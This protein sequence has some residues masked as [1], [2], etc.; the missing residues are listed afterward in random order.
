MSTTVS[1]EFIDNTSFEAE[2]PQAARAVA[3]QFTALARDPE[4]VFEEDTS[5]AALLVAAAESW[6]DAGDDEA[7]FAVALEA[8]DA[9]GDAA[10]DKRVYLLDAALRTGKTGVALE[11]AEEIR[12]EKPLD[13]LIY[14]FIGESFN[15]VN[16]IHNAQVWLNRGIRMLDSLIRDSEGFDPEEVAEML[17][18]REILLLDRQLIRSEA[19]LE[20]DELDEEALDILAY[21]EENGDIDF[22]ETL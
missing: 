17:E 16:D 7:A 21:H 5:P 9:E 1:W 15:E 12:Q 4:T 18:D 2:T 8:Q 10:P 11:I 22:D 14:S 6:Y 19:G 13:P 3:E 20:S